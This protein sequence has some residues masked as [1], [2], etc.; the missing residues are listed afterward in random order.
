MKYKGRLC[1]G[2]M[3]FLPQLSLIHILQLYKGWGGG[4]H[5]PPAAGAPD[6]HKL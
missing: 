1:H 5:R 2:L 4:M 6:N 3:G